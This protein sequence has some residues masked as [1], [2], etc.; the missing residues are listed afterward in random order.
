MTERDS[1][2]AVVL[3]DPADDT[4]RLVLAD[5]LRESDDPVDQA[6]GRFLWA[7]VTASRYRR[8][9]LINDRLYY[10]AQQEL[11]A[12]SATGFPARWVADLG[13]DPLV[14]TERDWAWDSEHDR[15]SF[16]VGP[17]RAVFARGL[18]EELSAPFETWLNVA[19]VALET[20][21]LALGAITDIA[22]LTF[23]IEGTCD[24]IVTARLRLPRRRVPLADRV[25]PSAMAPIPFLV[26]E[27]ADFEAT[28]RFV[29]RSALTG[30][31]AAA[32]RRLLSDLLQSAGDR[33]PRVGRS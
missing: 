11:A 1:L 16:R 9:E 2:L 32:S 23:A 22:G 33:W 28:E 31:I 25:I 29:D 3:N 17:V 6:L 30:G 14:V 27:P 8:D 21:P 18:I 10:T 12:I 7:G 15:V 26:E 13:L 5:W 4:V 20:W 24:W 19:P